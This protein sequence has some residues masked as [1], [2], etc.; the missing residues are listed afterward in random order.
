MSRL[1]LRNGNWRKM[2]YEKVVEEFNRLIR[3]SDSYYEYMHDSG[4]NRP[5]RE[6]ITKHKRKNTI[7]RKIIEE[8]LLEDLEK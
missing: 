2:K 7:I 1:W 5:S 8:K 4:T 6:E 3:E